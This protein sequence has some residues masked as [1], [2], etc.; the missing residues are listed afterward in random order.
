MSTF[1]ISIMER[2]PGLGLNDRSIEGSFV[3]TK[4]DTSSLDSGRQI[5]QNIIQIRTV[6]TLLAQTMDT[7]GVTFHVMTASNSLFLKVKN[8]PAI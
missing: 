5:N 7:L 8:Y 4:K 1:N 6:Y 3:W 2:D